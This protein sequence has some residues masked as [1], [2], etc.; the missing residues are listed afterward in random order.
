M[1]NANTPDSRRNHSGARRPVRSD[2]WWKS[3][4][5][6]LILALLAAVA[7]WLGIFAVLR[8]IAMPPSAGD[9]RRFLT[10]AARRES[11]GLL[12]LSLIL[13]APLMFAV[14]TQWMLMRGR[15]ISRS[16]L[17][18][19]HIRSTRRLVQCVAIAQC[20]S[21]T[22]V[23][24][25]FVTFYCA[26]TMF[27]RRVELAR[28]L[29]A[30]PLAMATLPFA[31]R[32][33]ASPS[34]RKATLLAG[35][36]ALASLCIPIGLAVYRRRRLIYGNARLA[37]LTDA[38]DFGLRRR[39]GVV[40]GRQRGRLL[41]DD[42]D[43]HV[44]VI[45]SPGQG[46]SRSLVIPSIMRFG[47]SMFILDFGGELHREMSGWLGANGYRIYVIAP[48]KIETDCF[49]PFDFV[50]SDPVQRITDLQKLAMM[51]M[52]ERIRSDASDFWE[53]SARIL[54]TALMAFVIE[55]PDTRKSLGELHR[56]L[57]AMP[58]E[59]VVVAQLLKKY[60]HQLSDATC[61]QL[62]KFCGRHDKLAEGIAAEIAAKIDVLQNRNLEAMFAATTVPLAAIR[63]RK[64]AIFLDVD[65]Q[66]VR[67]FER[68]VSLIIETTMDVL[69]RQGPLRDGQHDVMVMLD[70]FGNAGRLDTILTQAP[71]MRKYGIRFVLTLQDS[72]QLERL[73]QKP[74]REIIAG[75]STLTLY[76]NFQ[77][78]RD[79][80][81][82]AAIAGKTTDWLPTSSYSY[83]HGRRDR[84]V[85]MLPVQRELLSVAD[86]MLLKPEEA[87]LHVA[88]APIFKLNKIDGGNDPRFCDCARYP[89]VSRPRMTIVETRDMA[90]KSASHPHGALVYLSNLDGLRLRLGLQSPLLGTDGGWPHRPGGGQGEL[91][92]NQT[93]VVHRSSSARGEAES[94][95]KAGFRQ[96]VADHWAASD[97][98]PDGLPFADPAAIEAALLALLDEVRPSI[99]PQ[100]AEAFRTLEEAV[101]NPLQDDDDKAM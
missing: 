20:L 24:V 74:G 27:E 63:N 75:A 56:I 22:A 57:G 12:V 36:S 3:P 78:P 59:H 70:E 25:Y 23:A 68:F 84:Q 4:A 51:I 47:G 11:L 31:S 6:T 38:A 8:D 42:S 83:R 43:R 34:V 91:F 80:L 60:R 73:Y 33:A 81:H 69:V 35:L 2:R 21:L 14:L 87:I 19:M 44:L 53:E 7:L 66:T 79:A 15:T 37:T 29:S 48:G 82:V 52:P 61:M 1:A 28:Y 86:L 55:C 93:A 40:L 18:H 67:V 10:L 94:G 26:A 77:N 39:R 58:E 98:W 32:M 46:K 64:M 41:I 100:A 96:A 17:Y 89:A 72:A 88:G 50:S 30:R 54:L 9:A 16:L 71:L 76:M 49:N 92:G 95:A 97:H 99:P 65:M 90:R 62:E 13:A 85:S 101:S 5:A 45:G